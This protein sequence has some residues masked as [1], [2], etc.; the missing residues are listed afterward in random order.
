MSAFTEQ[1]QV[2][3]YISTPFCGTCQVAQ[4]IM[5]VVEELMPQLKIRKINA[6]Y[7]PEHMEEWQVESVPCLLRWNN[8]K[9]E[10]KVYAFHSVPHMYEYVGKFVT[11]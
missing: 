8:G 3:L 11:K 1:E 7:F 10:D 5:E 4:K 6:N 9:I 2:F